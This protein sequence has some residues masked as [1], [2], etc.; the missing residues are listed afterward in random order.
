MAVLI[1]VILHMHLAAGDQ[2]PA[3]AP[4][5]AGRALEGGNKSV[6][7]NNSAGTPPQETRVISVIAT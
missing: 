4:A 6:A 1:A 3:V 5:T 2:T 7:L